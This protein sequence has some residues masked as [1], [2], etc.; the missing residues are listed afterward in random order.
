MDRVKYSVASGAI[1]E[2]HAGCTNS[3]VFESDNDAEDTP[4]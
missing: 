3:E 2:G 4:I 1:A